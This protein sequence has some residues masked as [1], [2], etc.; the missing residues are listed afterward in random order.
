MNCVPGGGVGVDVVPEDAV[1]TCGDGG[2][3]GGVDE[4]E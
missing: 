3:A 4:V 1:Q 2:D